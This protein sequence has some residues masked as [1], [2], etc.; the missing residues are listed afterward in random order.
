[1]PAAT[2]VVWQ[3]DSGTLL[4]AGQ[5]QELSACRVHQAWTHPV[6]GLCSSGQRPHLRSGKAE[7]GGLRLQR[8]RP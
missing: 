1:M 3:V 2:L 7:G 6:L 5:G 8:G 4:V